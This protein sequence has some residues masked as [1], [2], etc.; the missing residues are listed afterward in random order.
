LTTG[1]ST[2]IGLATTSITVRTNPE[3]LAPYPGHCE[4]YGQ[5]FAASSTA[6]IKNIAASRSAHAL[7]ETVLVTTFSVAGLK[8]TFHNKNPV[9]KIM[10]Q[11]D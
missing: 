4:L 10:T 6:A 2:P 5:A 3:T 7:A 9:L 1:S 8:C 11:T